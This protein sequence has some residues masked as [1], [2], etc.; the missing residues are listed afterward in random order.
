MQITSTIRINDYDANQYTVERKRTVMSGKRKGDV[1]W[2]V[3]D[4]CGTLKGLS[5]C[6]ERALIG[7]A[8]S[9]AKDAAKRLFEHNDWDNRIKTELVEKKGKVVAT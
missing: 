8:M 2:D 5:A 7:E 6:V 3:L 1:V 9:E 4:Y